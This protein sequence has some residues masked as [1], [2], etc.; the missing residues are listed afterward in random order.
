MEH[1]MQLH[2]DRLEREGMQSRLR[3]LRMAAED[4]TY[5]LYGGALSY[6]EGE[7]LAREITSVRTE[8]ATLERRLREKADA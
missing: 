3:F 7:A 8:I 4:A 5:D 2:Y 1:S 6:R